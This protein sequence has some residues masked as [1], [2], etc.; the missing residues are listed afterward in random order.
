MKINSLSDIGVKR[1]DNQDNF[2]SARLMVDG[3]EAGI[4]CI[5]DGMGGLDDGG[6]AS[7]IVVSDVREYL[8]NHV[9]VKGLLDVL[10][11]SNDTIRT[12]SKA[13]EKS[14]GTTCTV[15][16][17]MDGVYEI[18]HIGDSRCYLLRDHEF[19][20]LTKDHSALA[21]YKIT[22]KNDPE[23]YKKYKN[24]L[25]RCIGVQENIDVDY[26]TGEYKPGDMF[27][28][29]SDGLWHYFDDVVFNEDELFNLPELVQKCIWYGE[30]DN[31]TVS[32]LQM[33]E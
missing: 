7:K 19:T 13:D 20:P 25:T 15:I 27:L 5:C 31:I 21:K 2:W 26:Y 33:G 30:T 9:G 23:M 3:S 4:V 29:C 32:T 8:T 10:S 11:R 1:K 22:K 17:C 12:L 16:V 14:M 6:L 18:A 24:K 28:C